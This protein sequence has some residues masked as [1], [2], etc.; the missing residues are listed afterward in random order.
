MSS[1]VARKPIIV[2]QSVQVTV[3]EHN[4]VT[5]KGPKGRAVMKIHTACSLLIENSELKVIAHP[6]RAED[7][8]VQA[9][10][11]RS[12][13]NSHIIGVTDGFMK[14]LLLIGVGYRA[15]VSKKGEQSLLELTLGLSHPTVYLAPLG[16]DI[17]V[18]SATEVEIR[19]SDRQKVGQVAADIR[20]FR[21]PEP[22]K[23]KGV[24]YSDERI[25]LKET[26]KK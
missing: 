12:L 9:G 16:I 8:D 23:G 25:V 15:K 3:D 10:T 4:T 22:Y 18:P 11:V 2:P 13:M 26:K 1:R 6:E 17:T 24:R 14:K 20:S 5:V 7:S 19:G 21:P